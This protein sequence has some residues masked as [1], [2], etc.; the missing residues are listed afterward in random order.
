MSE[1]IEKNNN[2]NDVIDEI[3]KIQIGIINEVTNIF[4][5]IKQTYLNKKK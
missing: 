4:L 5:I 3:E 1:I 2:Q